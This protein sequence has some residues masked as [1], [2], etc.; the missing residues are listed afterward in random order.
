M[1]EYFQRLGVKRGNNVFIG[2]DQVSHADLDKPDLLHYISLGLFKHMLEW[3]AGFLKK[4]K[5]QQAFNDAWK[6]NP[7]YPGFSELKKA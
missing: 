7:P 6:E 2:L 3:V 5:Q 1:A 4:N